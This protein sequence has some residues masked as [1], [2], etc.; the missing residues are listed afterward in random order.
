[1]AKGKKIYIWR[2]CWYPS[3]GISQHELKTD[4]STVNSRRWNIQFSVCVCLCHPRTRMLL[5]QRTE[6][7]DSVCWPR[8]APLYSESPSKTIPPFLSCK[9]RSHTHWPVASDFASVR[10]RISFQWDG[11]DWTTCW[12]GHHWGQ[13]HISAQT[14][15]VL[16]GSKN[17]GWPAINAD[18]QNHHTRTHTHT[19]TRAHARECL[20]FTVVLKFLPNVALTEVTPLP[21]DLPVSKT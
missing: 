21:V 14:I 2:K 9:I 1:M 3:P 17:E 5:G 19:H 11:G 6:T 4:N 18:L 7:L 13:T 8:C 16:H 20:C 12:W 10:S 15:T